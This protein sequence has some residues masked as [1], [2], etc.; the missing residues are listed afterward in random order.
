MRRRTH[1]RTGCNT[2]NQVNSV[3]YFISPL[4]FTVFHFHFSFVHQHHPLKISM[5]R[6]IACVQTLIPRPCLM[7]MAFDFQFSCVHIYADGRDIYACVN[8]IYSR[9]VSAEDS[10]FILDQLTRIAHR[11]HIFLFFCFFFVGSP[12][13]KHNAERNWNVSDFSRK[14]INDE[15]WMKQ[16]QHQTAW[17][18]TE[19]PFFYVDSLSW[20]QAFIHLMASVKFRIKWK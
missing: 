14:K 15:I 9:V 1:V 17:C 4:F 7:R 11:R 18:T 6:H 20:D 10:F 16:M 12:K 13:M 2:K 5:L 8:N 19:I 3:S